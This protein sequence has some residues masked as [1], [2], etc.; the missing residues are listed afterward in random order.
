[1]INSS[2]V[3][4]PDLGEKFGDF[5]DEIGDL[6]G[7]EIFS[8]F[9]L[10]EKIRLNVQDNSMLRHGLPGK[11][12]YGECLDDGGVLIDWDRLG[13]GTFCSSIRCAS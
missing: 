10:G 1:M 7:A 11:T 13:A 9:Q 3:W 5:G 2:H 6:K 12:I 4:T 8:I